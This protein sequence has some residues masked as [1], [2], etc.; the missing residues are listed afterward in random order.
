[1]A[2]LL[3]QLG[4]S[5]DKLGKNPIGISKQDRQSRRSLIQDNF[6]PK[7]QLIHRLTYWDHQPH[8]RKVDD[9]LRVVQLH[10]R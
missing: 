3:M 10:H 4:A 2:L 8:Q 7:L 5:A 9:A 6:G 1:M